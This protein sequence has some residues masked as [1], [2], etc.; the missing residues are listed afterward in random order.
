MLS[1][2]VDGSDKDANK[3]P[4]LLSTT[5][6]ILLILRQQFENFHLLFIDPLSTNY[7]IFKSR[8]EATNIS[9]NF[10]KSPSVRW[11]ICLNILKYLIQGPQSLFAAHVLEQLPL[12]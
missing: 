12:L 7:G 5:L 6:P 4:F 11:F 9:L 8:L 1:F 10:G 2:H 3:G